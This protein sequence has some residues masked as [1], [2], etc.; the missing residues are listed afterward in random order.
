MSITSIFSKKAKKDRKHFLGIAFGK[1]AEKKIDLLKIIE[2]KDTK[3]LEQ[4]DPSKFNEVVTLSNGVSLGMTYLSYAVGCE[5]FAGAAYM[6]ENGADAKTVDAAGMNIITKAAVMLGNDNPTNEREKSF[7]KMLQLAIKGGADINHVDK[8]G[9]TAI[10]H[11]VST[12]YPNEKF[13]IDVVKIL[14]PEEGQAAEITD[15]AIR[16]SRHYDRPNLNQLLRDTR[17]KQLKQS[18]ITKKKS[19]TLAA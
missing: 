9:G 6:L 11:T 12:N 16:H 19:Q 4:V 3:A 2:N 14:A 18:N 15:E 5:D 13:L 8:Q 10:L 1:K 17:A 7:K